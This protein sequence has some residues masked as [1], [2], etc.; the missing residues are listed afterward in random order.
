MIPVHNMGRL[1][2]SPSLQLAATFMLF[3]ASFLRLMVTM[4][5]QDSHGN[6]VPR[7]TGLLNVSNDNPISDSRQISRILQ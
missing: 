3:H 5:F 7:F 6:A 4:S 2:F 1:L